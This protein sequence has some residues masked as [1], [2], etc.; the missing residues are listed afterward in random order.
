MGTNSNSSFWKHQNY[1]PI[2][3]KEDS[4]VCLF[5][6]LFCGGHGTGISSQVFV[7]AKLML[8]SMSHNSNVFCSDCFGD[9][10]SK[11]FAWT[12]VNPPSSWCQP[13]KL[14][15]LGHRHLVICNFH[16]DISC[17]NF[18]HKKEKLW[19]TNGMK[20]GMIVMIISLVIL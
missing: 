6:C 13:L 11:L 18:T 3:E 14:I 17:N 4:F 19:I 5:V 20:I 15:G 9:S 7:F 2:T 10:I 8:Y 12:G 16:E 1:W